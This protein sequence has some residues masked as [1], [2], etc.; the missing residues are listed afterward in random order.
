M[1]KTEELGDMATNDVYVD[2][3][4]LLDKSLWFLE[5]HIQK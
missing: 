4:R 3:A 5:A 1:I 2:L